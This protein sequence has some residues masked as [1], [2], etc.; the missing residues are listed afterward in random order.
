LHKATCTNQRGPRGHL[1]QLEGITRVATCTN[2]VKSVHCTARIG[3]IPQANGRYSNSCRAAAHTRGHAGQLLDVLP[4][5]RDDIEPHGRRLAVVARRLPMGSA[6]RV[7][8]Y[9]SDRL[10]ACNVS[11]A[12]VCHSPAPSITH[13]SLL[14]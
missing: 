3:R 5:R 14:E 11:C 1:N 2:Q 8:C 10:A 12:M 9:W 4:D 6:G 7:C 13:I